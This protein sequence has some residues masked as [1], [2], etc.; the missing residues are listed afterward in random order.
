MSL[1]KDDT[2]VLHD[3]DQY[4]QEK[5]LSG[6]ATLFCPYPFSWSLR[7]YK[8]QTKILGRSRPTKHHPIIP[9][10]DIIK[11]FCMTLISMIKKSYFQ[12]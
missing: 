2:E 3:F 7:I 4:D 1:T 6:R 12:K 5:L 11:M 8:V 10:A 9:E